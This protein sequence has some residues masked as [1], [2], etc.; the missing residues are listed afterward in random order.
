[1][2]LIPYE[3]ECKHTITV[4][5]DIDSRDGAELDMCSNCGAIIHF[6]DDDIE[7]VGYAK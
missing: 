5:Y 4:P 6:I 7:I 1:M 2:N 3:N